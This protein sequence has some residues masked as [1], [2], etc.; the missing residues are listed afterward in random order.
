MSLMKTIIIN[1]FVI[2]Y[3]SAQDLCPPA[4]LNTLFY[5]ENMCNNNKS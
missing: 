5:D 1:L 3:V 4:L 2:V